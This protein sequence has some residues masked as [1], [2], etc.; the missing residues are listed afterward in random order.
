[1]S[2]C[3]S[4]STYL[5]G[6]PRKPLPSPRTPLPSQHGPLGWHL[7]PKNENPRNSSVTNELKNSCHLYQF[8]LSFDLQIVPLTTFHSFIH[9]KIKEYSRIFWGFYREYGIEYFGGLFSIKFR[10]LVIMYHLCII[11][12]SMGRSS[13]RSISSEAGIYQPPRLSRKKF[14]EPRQL[15]HFN[16]IVTK[17]KIVI[18][19]ISI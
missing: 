4:I 8:S 3:K 17:V 9:R 7:P 12:L 14:P 18:F 1:M 6:K 15:D 16:E 11:N 13:A 5:F 10:A 2:F 19:K